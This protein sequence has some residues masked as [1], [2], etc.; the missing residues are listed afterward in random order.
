MLILKTLN[1]KDKDNEL[2]T[3]QMNYQIIPKYSLKPQGIFL[4]KGSLI[5]DFSGSSQSHVS[6]VNF[7]K[8]ITSSMI[9][10]DL[11]I[12]YRNIHMKPTHFDSCQK[13]IQLMNKS[14]NK[15]LISLA[16]KLEDN[17]VRYDTDKLIKENMM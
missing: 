2:T 9:V 12:I 6:N 3:K 5:F 8:S 10:R 7:Y 11:R 16:A 15:D 14:D 13:V 17:D 1:D 4:L